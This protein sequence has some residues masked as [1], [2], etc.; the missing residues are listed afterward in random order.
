MTGLTRENILFS[1]FYFMNV[2][3]F[4]CVHAGSDVVCDTYYEGIT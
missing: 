4:K 1:K 2:L 3:L